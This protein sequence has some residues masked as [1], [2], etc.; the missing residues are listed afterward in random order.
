M[1]AAF[2][3]YDELPQYIMGLKSFIWIKSVRNTIQKVIC[4]NSCQSLNGAGMEQYTSNITVIIPAFNAGRVLVRALDS[5]LR[6]TVQPTEVIVVNDGSIDDTQ[7]VAE[8]YAVH[9]RLPLRVLSKSNGGVSSARNLGIQSALTEHVALLDADDE[10]GS[11]HIESVTAAI[12][13]RPD[14]PLYWTGIARQFDAGGEAEAGSLPDFSAIARRHV[15]GDPGD[16]IYDALPSAFDELLKGSYIPTSASVFKRLC[17]G[18][19]NL[20][21]EQLHFGEDWLFYLQLLE[22]GGVFIDRVTAII[23]RDGSNAS[24][25][26]ADVTKLLVTNERRIAAFESAG[27]LPSISN[28]SMRARV[29]GGRMRQALRDRIYYASF[30]GVRATLDAVLHSSESP[31]FSMVN[32]ASLIA[33]NFARAGFYT[34]WGAPP[35]LKRL[36]NRLTSN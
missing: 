11:M 12:A 26:A 24:I 16:G 2:D 15:A 31:Y 34:T 25:T 33:R 17:N 9:H 4:S 30:H 5:V 18:R 10:F 23:H 35:R 6:Q 20:F 19:L 36:R 8:T 13:V 29:L 1:V 22:R 28:D 7:L 14:A 3:G 32:H 21:D 27:L